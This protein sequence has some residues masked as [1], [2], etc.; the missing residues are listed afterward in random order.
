M[1][2]KGP[3]ALG[4]QILI[5][6]HATSD[7][8]PVQWQVE[9][10]SSRHARGNRRHALDSPRGVEANPVAGLGSLGHTDHKHPRVDL[11]LLPR[12]LALWHAE[13]DFLASRSF[14][15]LQVPIIADG[16]QCDEVGTLGPKSHC[17]EGAGL[18]SLR[19]RHSE[20][21]VRTLDG[22]V[23]LTWCQVLRHLEGEVHGPHRASVE[24]PRRRCLAFF[25]SC[26]LL[27][28]QALPRGRRGHH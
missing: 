27:V 24:D 17:G 9:V 15:C 7:S 20:R 19:Y 18:S 21:A 10:L 16:R 22:N 23:T 12:P 5:K 3:K 14:V 2:Q 28:R 8:R 6:A 26:G 13:A 1:A 11:E 25:R 4:C